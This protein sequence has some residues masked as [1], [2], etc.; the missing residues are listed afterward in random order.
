MGHLANTAAAWR[1]EIFAD[2]LDPFLRQPSA[3][4]WFV[5]TKSGF[6]RPH[7]QDPRPEVDKNLANKRGWT[8]PKLSKAFLAA[9]PYA[10]LMELGLV[11]HNSVEVQVWRREAW[12]PFDRKLG[13]FDVLRIPEA[14][15]CQ[16]KVKLGLRTH[17]V[18]LPA[19]TEIAY[20]DIL[21]FFTEQQPAAAQALVSAAIS[22][23]AP[24]AG[25]PLALPTLRAEKARLSAMETP[26]AR[27]RL[28][29]VTW[30]LTDL[31]LF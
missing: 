28:R 12:V 16:V 2:K 13:V 14:K 26:E 20:A 10:E 30:W 23:G 9:H 21:R 31:Y 5:M 18:T 7:G 8:S 6:P 22:G 27:E 3:Y 4:R 24:R 1:Q 17:A 25:L 11:P 15:E 19:G 29:T